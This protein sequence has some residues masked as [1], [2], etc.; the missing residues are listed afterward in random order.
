M[1]GYSPCFILTVMKV[2][3]RKTPLGQCPGLPLL[4]QQTEA[5]ALRNKDE[6]RPLGRWSREFHCLPNVLLQRR[7]TGAQVL[8]GPCVKGPGPCHW[9]GQCWAD[10]SLHLT[11]QVSI[12][13]TGV[14]W[15]GHWPPTQRNFKGKETAKF[16]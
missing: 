11:P 3:L 8:P 12:Q 13:Q 2:S 6:H 5:E 1:D 16:H 9:G 4:V 14:N 7:Q 15:G 10:L